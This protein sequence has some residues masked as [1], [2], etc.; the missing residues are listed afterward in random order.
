[1]QV[2]DP[3]LSSSLLYAT[4]HFNVVFFP[5]PLPCCSINHWLWT[6]LGLRSRAGRLEA[7]SGRRGS[8]AGNCFPGRD[9]LSE[10]WAEVETGLLLFPSNAYVCQRLTLI[11]KEEV[12]MKGFMVYTIIFSFGAALTLFFLHVLYYHV[13]SFFAFSLS[14]FM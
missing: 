7:G 10:S 12:D 2:S 5:S 14:S 9:W 3:E 6:L 4:F 1:M 8:K 13:L 11:K